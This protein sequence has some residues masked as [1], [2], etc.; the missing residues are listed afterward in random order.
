LAIKL[1]AFSYSLIGCFVCCY[2]LN[3]SLQA[4]AQTQGPRKIKIAIYGGAG[5]HPR[6]QLFKALAAQNDFYFEEVNGEDIADRCLDKFDMLLVPGGSGKREAGSLGI[7]GRDAIRNFV[8]NGG[9]YIGICAGCYL[10]SGGLPQYLGILPAGLVD[11]A[12]QHWRRGKATLH[13]DVTPFGHEILGVKENDFAVVY[14]NGPV[15]KESTACGEGKLTPLA[16]YRDE[17][18]APGGKIGVM[19]GSPAMVLASYHKGIVIGISPHPEA[20]PG[21][22]NVIPHVIRWLWA[23]HLQ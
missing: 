13:V 15:I 2:L 20:T 7:E 5:A 21:L 16:I 3:P 9:S 4:N 11:H 10:A 12:H 17:V 23:H 8:A 22:E 19:A 1:R 18:V 6:P 14:H